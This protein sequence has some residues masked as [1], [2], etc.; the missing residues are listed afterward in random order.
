MEIEG[1]LWLTSLTTTASSVGSA[2]D[3]NS[4][5]VKNCCNC[6]WKRPGIRVWG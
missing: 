6:L 4:S 5:E 1:R 3:S 2:Y